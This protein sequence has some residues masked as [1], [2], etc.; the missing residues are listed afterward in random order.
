MYSPQPPSLSVDSACPALYDPGH[1]W[2]VDRTFQDSGELLPDGRIIT[3]HRP[4]GAKLI[5]DALNAMGSC[6][7]SAG[8]GGAA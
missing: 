7:P 3:P 5:R 8:T 4:D 2:R 6:G 1:R